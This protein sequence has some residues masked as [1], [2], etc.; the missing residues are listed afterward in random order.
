MKTFLSILFLIAASGVFADD[1]SF[2]RQFFHPAAGRYIQ[3]ALPAASNLVVRGLALRPN[4]AKLLELKKLIEQQQKKNQERKNDRNKKDDSKKK[5]DEKKKEENRKKQE[6]NQ[7]P[8]KKRNDAGKKPD[9]SAP[10][11]GKSGSEKPKRPPGSR[12]AKP[13]E[14]SADEAKRLLDAMKQDERKN[15]RKLRPVVMGA[16]VRVDKDW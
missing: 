11:P 13:K 1:S 4:D 3:G 15:R 6:G 10:P 8:K 2:D 14:M 12:P 16:P 9:G 5:N 7:P